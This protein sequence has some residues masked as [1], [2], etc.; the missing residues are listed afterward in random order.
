MAN[1]SAADILG[2]AKSKSAFSKPKAMKFNPL[3]EENIN[4]HIISLKYSPDQKWIAAAGISGKIHV[5]DAVSGRPAHSLN[6]HT[7]GVRMISWSRG[8]EFLT[9][10]GQDGKI[11]L[12]ETNGFSEIETLFAGSDWVECV[13][14]SPHSDIFA[15]AAGKKIRLWTANGELIHDYPDQLSTVVDLAWSPASDEFATACY[16]GLTRWRAE[17][18][19]PL[20]KYQWKGS[21]L[22]IAWSPNGKYIATGDQDSTVH[23]WIVKSGKDLQM[24][25]YPTK[26]KELSWDSSSRFLA[27]G[28]GG[29][30]TVWNCEPSPQGTL[31]MQLN[32]HQNYLSSLAFQPRGLLLLSGDLDGKIS[33][34]DIGRE[35]QF[36]C[37]ANLPGEITNIVWANDNT[38]FAVSDGDG[39][40]RIYSIE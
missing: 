32:G 29:A 15:S 31:P 30:V 33:L 26:V 2:A 20:H 6:A 18:T 14:W 19:V 37:S 35:S 12:F 38:R 23:F 28:G 34:W 27:T 25:G 22:V 9:S 24:Y 11:R 1:L 40:V 8:G 10:A 3:R 13:R 21:T 17:T 5:F 16:G 39:T 7:F 36:Q 4:D